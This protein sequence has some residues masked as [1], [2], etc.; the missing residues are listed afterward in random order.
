MV[1]F[2]ICTLDT[3]TNQAKA[4]AGPEEDA[5]H[6]FPQSRF[7]GALLVSHA[8]KRIMSYLLLALSMEATGNKK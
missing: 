7:H 1:Q 8:S 4:S 6:P 5:A 3:A 2:T